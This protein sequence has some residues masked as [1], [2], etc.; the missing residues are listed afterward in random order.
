MY[1]KINTF[2]SEISRALIIRNWM[3]F[4]IEGDAGAW[5]R[6]YD[7]S[8]GTFMAGKENWIT[9]DN[10][11]GFNEGNLIDLGPGWNIYN[12]DV[13][14]KIGDIHT[15]SAND[16]ILTIE[17]EDIAKHITEDSNG[18]I[19]FVL[20]KLPQNKW[21]QRVEVFSNHDLGKE[22][23][24]SFTWDDDVLLYGDQIVKTHLMSIFS[25]TPPMAHSNYSN[26]ETLISCDIWNLQGKRY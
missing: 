3:S 23:R 21:A 26:A 13:L 5:T 22:P 25:P 12:E 2:P 16:S 20:G 1:W 11:P 4:I 6:V 14:I 24:I 8:T 7:G 15:L 10:A 19:V 9:A 18:V 17:H